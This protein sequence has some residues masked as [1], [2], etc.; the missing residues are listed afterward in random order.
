MPNALRGGS[1]SRAAPQTRLTALCCTALSLFY[2][3]ATGAHA[4]SC[5]HR[6]E[7]DNLYCDVDQNLTADAP[8][9]PAKLKNPKSILLS[10]SP[11]EDTAT[12]EK[13]WSPYVRFMAQCLGRPMRFLQVHSSTATIEA[14]RSGRIQMSLLAAG[15]TPFAVNVAGAIPFAIHGNIINGKPTLMAYHLIM[16]VRADSPYK[17]MRDLAGK[18]VAHVAPSSN[19]GNLAPRALF[20]DVGLTPDKDYKVLYSGKHDNS[21]TSVING[22]Y[23]AAAV[24]DDVLTRMIQRGAVKEGELRVL[25][26]SR[27]FPAGSLAMVHDLAPALRDQITKCTFDFT[28]PSELI[29]AFRGTDRFVPLNYK[30]DYE[31][32]RRVAEQSGE[33]FSRTAFDKRKAFE[34]AAAAKPTT[35]KK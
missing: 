21:I 24:A 11:Q 10:Y 34:A 28:F 26:K 22:D 18:R 30:R 31:S 9:D 4:Q 16:V 14:M 6:G 8:T 3:S 19:S 17:T 25:Y 20:P 23:D 7:L 1:G 33:A 12:Y 32:V 2:V 29:T 5:T 35:A 15:D 27:P 13:M